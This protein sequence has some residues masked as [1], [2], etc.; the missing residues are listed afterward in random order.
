MLLYPLFRC[1][2]QNGVPLGIGDYLLAVRAL[3]EGK[4]LNEPDD[5]PF[6]LRLLWAKSREDQELFDEAFARLVQPQ[7]T[8]AAPP[9][10]RGPTE[11]ARRGP[12]Q[13]PVP[14]P[15][16]P[17]R[18]KGPEPRGGMAPVRE[19]VPSRLL[20]LPERPA[21][22][23]PRPAG[24]YQLTPRLLLSR[25]EM[26]AVWRQL[27]RPRRVG[28]PVDLDV[29]ATVRD[30]CRTGFFLRPSLL[31][32][33]RNLARLVVLLDRSA[34]MAPFAPLV[35][36]LVESTRRGGLLGQTALYHFH[37]YPA[38]A[39]ARPGELTPHWPLGTVLAEE[40]KRNSVLI[41]SDAGAARGD[42]RRSRLDKT[43][44]FLKA[45]REVTYLY[46]WVNPLPRDRWAAGTAAAIARLVPMFP[47]DRE[48]LLDAVNILRGYPFPPGVHPD[49][50]D[51]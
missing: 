40:A 50:T 38:G 10:P 49:A 45:L 44:A 43:R 34:S 25:R 35:D 2:R 27:R 46:A 24:A 3:R 12:D 42:F 26:T 11:E 18:K 39:L 19:E 51:R 23:A 36:A 14:P 29:E 5:F 31:P 32:R 4:G 22:P 15:L 30:V 1:L 16:P 21:G 47:L 17:P 7:L 6:L 28:P 9:P 48:G 33:R 41:V 8:P 37:N 13:P 20:R